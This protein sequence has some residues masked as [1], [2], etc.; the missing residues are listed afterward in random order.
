LAVLK[1]AD[2][3]HPYDLDIL[4]GLISMLREAGNNKAALVYAQKAAQALP[5]NSE[6]K[7]LIV[8]LRGVK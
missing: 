8:E 3:R 7:N 5:D 6:I 2:R 1:A 4:S